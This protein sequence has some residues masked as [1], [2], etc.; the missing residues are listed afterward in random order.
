MKLTEE[1]RLAM[2][3]EAA[4]LQAVMGTPAGRRF[5]WRLL[6]RCGTF[7]S[8]WSPSAEIHLKAGM[9]QVGLQYLADVHEHCFD[10]YQ[11]MEREAREAAL[12]AQQAREHPSTNEAN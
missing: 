3:E 7:H 8:G 4:D 2:A 5:M 6:A 11:A 1:Q 10:A 9:R 12:R